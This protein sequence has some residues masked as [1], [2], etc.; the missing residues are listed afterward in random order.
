MFLPYFP[1]LVQQLQILA[2]KKNIN[3]NHSTKRL[4]EKSS[5][6]AF[7]IFFRKIWDGERGETISLKYIALSKLSFTCIQIAV[8]KSYITNCVLNCTKICLNQLHAFDN[9]KSFVLSLITA[10]AKCASRDEVCQ[11]HFS[12]IIQVIYTIALLR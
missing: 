6:I 7:F 12:R 2:M 1:I 10:E 5:S 11:A 8:T 3:H 4:L 9:W